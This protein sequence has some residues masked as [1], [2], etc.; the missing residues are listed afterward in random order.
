MGFKFSSRRGET[1]SLPGTVAN[2]TAASGGYSV[3]RF[4]TA[5]G[6]T[7][8]KTSQP[9]SA[10]SGVV[11]ST[12]MGERPTATNR[13][14]KL[15]YSLLGALCSQSRRLIVRRGDMSGRRIFQLEVSK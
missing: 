11:S 2:L 3:A 5:P 8:R 1:P 4:G 7:I 14:I 12:Q 10:T 15:P 13:L 6:A 9:T